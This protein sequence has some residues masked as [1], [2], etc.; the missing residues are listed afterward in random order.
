MV[1][2]T[3][4]GWYV[5]YIDRDPRAI[6]RQAMAEQ[7]VRSELDDEERAKRIIAAQIAAA[8]GGGG[9]GG[10]EDDDDNDDDDDEDAVESQ[11]LVR[12]EGTGKIELTL[13]FGGGGGGGGGGVGDGKKR[14]RLLLP[15]ALSTFGEGAVSSSSSSSSASLPFGVFGAADDE[16]G[17]PVSKKMATS[18]SSSSSSFSSSSSSSSS[19]ASALPAPTH[20]P[21]RSALDQIMQEEEQRKASLLL[22]EDKRDRKENWLHPNIVVKVMNKKLADGRFYKLKGTVLRVIDT[23]VGEIRVD[24][25]VVRLD[26]QDL[27]TVIPKPGNLV[28]IVNGRCRGLRATLLRINEEAF[29]CDLRVEEGP[30]TRR[31]ISGVE[32]EDVSK[33]GDDQ[34]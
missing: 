12:E 2:E 26:Q 7:R 14:P 13:S 27:E 30:H 3:E 15:S 29:T 22:I 28:L 20:A 17:E 24:G 16:P 32:Y 4:K 18:S 33:L 1:D 25:A 34:P 21:A 23:F 6:A 31:E 11:G 5:Q 19:S 9:G 8:G 10:G